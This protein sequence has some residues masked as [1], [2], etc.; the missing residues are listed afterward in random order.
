MLLQ[1]LFSKDLVMAVDL[2]VEFLPTSRIYLT[3]LFQIHMF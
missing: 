3:L 1:N 2:T